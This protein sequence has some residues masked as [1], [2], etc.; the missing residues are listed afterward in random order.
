M[1]WKRARTVSRPTRVRSRDRNVTLLLKVQ[2]DLTVA[3]R[4]ETVVPN[5]GFAR[6]GFWK[7]TAT[8]PEQMTPRPGRAQ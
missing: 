6:L 3:K 8:R 2:L 5:L 1:P 4:V 7:R